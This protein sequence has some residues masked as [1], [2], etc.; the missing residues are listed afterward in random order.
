[1]LQALVRV[2]ALSQGVQFL[3]LQFKWGYLLRKCY[4]V[5]KY[6]TDFCDG[7]DSEAL[8]ITLVFASRYGHHINAIDDSQI[9]AFVMECAKAVEA[10]RAEL[11][12]I[13]VEPEEEKVVEPLQEEDKKEDDNKGDEPK[14]WDETLVSTFEISPPAKRALAD[15]GLV[16]V[17]DVIAYEASGKPLVDIRG[18]SA[19]A[20]KIILDQIAALKPAEGS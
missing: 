8:S 10:M 9:A 17:K 14:P 12:E 18:I 19:T 5:A 6:V 1:M 16:T 15:A 2:L 13:E 4:A 3:K 20:A 11:D 7:D